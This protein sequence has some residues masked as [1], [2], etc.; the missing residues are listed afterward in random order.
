VYLT[1]NDGIRLYFDERGSGGAVLMIH[2]AAGSGKSFDPLTEH[3]QRDFRVVTVDL[4]GLSRSDR[5][6]GISATAWCDDTVA[7]ADFLGLDTFHL[8]GCSLGA[9]IAG[10]IARDNAGRVTTLTVDAPL[11]VVAQNASSS[12]NRRFEDLDHATPEDL[13]KWQRYHG[14]DWRR[15]VAFYGRVRNDPDLQAYLT[16]RPWLSELTLPTLI[17]RGDIDDSVHPLAHCTEWHGAHPESWLWIAADTGFSLTQ[18]RPAE[19]AD[20]YRRFV[21]HAA[22]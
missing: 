13:E 12:L 20:V 10:R 5:V 19:F 8:V 1:T 11:L 4:R 9:R 15:A 14:E 16:I 18:R 22:G 17:T 7:I 21:T 6:E 3:L 2:G